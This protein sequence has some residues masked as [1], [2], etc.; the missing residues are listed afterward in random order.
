M[1]VIDCIYVCAYVAVT[2]I[3]Q[4]HNVTGCL[5]GT[6]VFTCVMKFNNMWVNTDGITWWRRRIDDASANTSLS[7]KENPRFNIINN[8]N[9]TTLTS[10]LMIT[11]LR[12]AFIGPYWLGMVDGTQ[13][14]NVAFLSIVPNGMYVIMYAY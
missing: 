5:G 4:P 8:I 10:V 13:L 2:V 14:S 1:L 12:T 9:E 6:A 11:A 3:T 7:I